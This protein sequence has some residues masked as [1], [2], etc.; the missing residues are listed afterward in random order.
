MPNWCFNALTLIGEKNN[1]HKFNFEN[2][3]NE[4]DID[5]G[6]SVPFPSDRN[7]EKEWFE[8]CIENW[9]TKWSAS[10]TVIIPKFTEEEESTVIYEFC[11][12]WAP[13]IEWLTKVSGI[14]PDVKFE[15]KYHEPN[16]D[17]S[18]IYEIKNNDIIKQVNGIY[19]EYFGDRDIDCD[20][21]N[22]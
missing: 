22:F 5:F 15:L 14:Y 19:G 3:D 1:L 13:P 2:I 18:G 4:G 6:K 8:W 17:F 9:G 7:E 16:E 12:A 20:T 10:D 11:T 21:I